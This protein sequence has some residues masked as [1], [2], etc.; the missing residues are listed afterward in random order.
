MPEDTE[1]LNE[2]LEWVRLIDAAKEIG[3]SKAHLY[4]VAGRRDGPLEVKQ[5]GGGGAFRK[6]VY[7]SRRSLAKWQETR[8]GAKRKEKPPETERAGRQGLAIAS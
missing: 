4:N 3:V 5:M 6:E 7:I 2:E 8:P 1:R